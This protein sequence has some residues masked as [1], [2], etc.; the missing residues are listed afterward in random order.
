MEVFLFNEWLL[1]NEMR[2]L[3]VIFLVGWLLGELKGRIFHYSPDF[4]LRFIVGRLQ[5]SLWMF[6]SRADESG[7]EVFPVA[8]GAALP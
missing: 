6:S 4:H 8:T 7:R 3:L 5:R 2:I 1:A